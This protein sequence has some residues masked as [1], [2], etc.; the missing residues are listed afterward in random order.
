MAGKCFVFLKRSWL[1]PVLFPLN[2][3][4]YL[5][6]AVAGIELIKKAGAEVISCGCII[7]LPEL[8]GRDKL[9]E[10]PL[11]VLCEKEDTESGLA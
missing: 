7:E 5:K 8:K 10:I 2:L 4:L 11:Y 3:Y 6:F 1:L 9:G